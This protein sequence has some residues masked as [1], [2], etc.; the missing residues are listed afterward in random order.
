[1]AATHCAKAGAA[2]EELGSRAPRCPLR[3][4]ARLEVDF[5]RPGSFANVLEPLRATAVFSTL[6]LAASLPPSGCGAL[7]FRPHPALDVTTL[8]P[9]RCPSH[10][11]GPEPITACSPPCSPPRLP[12]SSCPLAPSLLRAGRLAPRC[13]G[14]APQGLEVGRQRCV[15]ARPGPRERPARSRPPRPVAALLQTGTSFA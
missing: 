13:P 12:S 11:P 1:M 6:V 14:Q 9:H 7:L 10:P 8:T 4:P 2:H 3:A 15:R 5:K